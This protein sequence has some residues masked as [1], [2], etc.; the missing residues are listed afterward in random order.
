MMQMMQMMQMKPLHE[1]MRDI[2][3]Y[4]HELQTLPHPCSLHRCQ[5]EGHSLHWTVT[6]AQQRHKQRY[7]LV[8]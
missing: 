7:F 4:L 6:I 3:T 5:V 8:L 2:S 1:T